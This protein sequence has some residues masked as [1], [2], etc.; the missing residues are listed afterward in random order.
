MCV[1]VLVGGWGGGG[2]GRGSNWSLHYIDLF[3]D[4]LL[5][6]GNDY[7]LKEENTNHNST[8]LGQETNTPF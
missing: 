2:R 4:I 3:V 1:C 5:C 7:S 6:F 8:R